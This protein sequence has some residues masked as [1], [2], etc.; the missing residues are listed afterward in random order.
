MM[1]KIPF[2]REVIL[3]AFYCD[4]CGYKNSEIQFGGR[5]SEHGNK[6]TLTVK[7]A[8]D[9]NRFVVKSEHASINI[10][11][12]QLEIPK[13]TQR[14][15]IN[16]VE[17]FLQKSVE[18]LNE[19]QEERKKKLMLLL[20]LKLINFWRKCRSSLMANTFHSHSKLMILLETAS[21]KTKM[22]LIQTLILL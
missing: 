22:P 8:K 14:G 19:G 12:L 1:T 13:I 3:M 6:L 16:T 2:F 20:L 17:G 4:H 18:G 11:E 5:I 7:D 15:T 10:P 21:F 9:M